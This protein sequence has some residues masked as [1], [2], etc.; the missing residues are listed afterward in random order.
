MKTP[1]HIKEINNG[2][3]RITFECICRSSACF[4]YP[5]NEENKWWF[6]KHKDCPLTDDGEIYKPPKER[7]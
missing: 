4:N 3:E 7:L 6:E 2:Q 1:D 5:V